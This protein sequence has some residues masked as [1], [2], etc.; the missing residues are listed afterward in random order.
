[1]NQ[2]LETFIHNIYI[3]K[4]YDDFKIKCHSSIDYLE[5][6]KI[7]VEPLCQEVNVCSIG[8]APSITICF[9]FDTITYPNYSVEFDTLL[10]IS[11]VADVFYIQHEFSIDNIAKNRMSAVLDGYDSQPYIKEQYLLEKSITDFLLRKDLK[12]LTLQE[13]QEVYSGLKIDENNLFGTQLT[14]ENAVFRDLCGIMD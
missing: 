2:Q 1:M 13:M 9:K 10:E 6:L 12:Q 4:N 11:K 7:L 14:V 8:N 5:Q 3:D